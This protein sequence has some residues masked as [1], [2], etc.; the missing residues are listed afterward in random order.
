MKE[1]YEPNFI[2][3]SDIYA[4]NY[5]RDEN[6]IR[7]NPNF[8]PNGI[9]WNLNGILAHE[10]GH[11]ISEN[12]DI[13]N[14]DYGSYASTYPIFSKTK[15]MNDVESQHKQTVTKDRS[16][17]ED[18]HDAYPKESYS[19]E[20]WFGFELFDSG[21]YD[22][23]KDE[24]FTQEHLNKYRQTFPNNNSR[25]LQ[26]F[27]DEDVITIMNTVADNGNNRKKDL[28]YAKKGTKLIPRKQYIK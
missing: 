27:S 4:A 14:P 21:I 26:N 24:P 23:T 6:T 17:Y 12:I 8:N 10:L 16:Y 3:T 7:L 25:F 1:L 11:W 13:Y 22:M 5:N 28:Y 2:E 9:N 19:D 18:Y 15:A 20:I